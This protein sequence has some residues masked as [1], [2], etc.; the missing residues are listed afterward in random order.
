MKA[1]LAPSAIDAS[2]REQEL[3]SGDRIAGICGPGRWLVFEYAP[4]ALF[5][6]KSSL[7]TSTA[8]ITLLVPTPY[9]VKMA[10]VDASFRAGF[11]YGLCAKILE[12]LVRI[13]VFI[14]PPTHAVVTQTFVKIRQE[15]RKGD[16]LRPYGPNVAYRELVHFS[17]KW[18]FAFDLVPQDD[19]VTEILVRCAPHVNYIGK[20]GSFIQYECAFRLLHLDETFTQPVQ[21]S[22]TWTIPARAHIA[23][24]DDFG[25]EA[26][27]RVLS[28]FSPA[29]A[30]AGRHRKFVRTLVPLGLVSTGPGFREYSRQQKLVDGCG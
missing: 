25:P 28:S 8:G 24:L 26:T 27:L 5:S 29:R 7:A 12:S 20:R 4:V 3:N 21:G 13:Q 11:D 6:L 9:A 2:K 18:R 1:P 19:E 30:E 14:S 22:A 17:G 10:F 16:P 15:S 23:D